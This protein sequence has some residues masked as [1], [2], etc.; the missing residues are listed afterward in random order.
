MAAPIAYD[1]SNVNYEGRIPNEDYTEACLKPF[2]EN[3]IKFSSTKF[4]DFTK[5]LETHFKLARFFALHNV[6][7]GTEKYPIRLAGE[8]QAHFTSRENIFGQRQRLVLNCLQQTLAHYHLAGGEDATHY[9]EQVDA[10]VDP[11]DYHQKLR[12]LT[13]SGHMVLCSFKSFI[14]F[15]PKILSLEIL[16]TML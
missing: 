12:E 2:E 7:N 13:S 8:S 10:I 14:S 11:F 6:L 16:S 15:L 4:H 3:K 1:A 5:H 9:L